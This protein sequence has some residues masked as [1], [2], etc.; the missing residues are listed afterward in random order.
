MMVELLWCECAFEYV[1]EKHTPPEW[2][3][4]L[5]NLNNRISVL[6][7][8]ILFATTGKKP[9]DHLQIFARCGGFFA[10]FRGEF[11]GSRVYFRI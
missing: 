6:K 8:S 9:P 3:S 2:K 1:F 7:L 5:I 4:Q 11:P 10:I